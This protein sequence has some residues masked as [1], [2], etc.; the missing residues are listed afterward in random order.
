M[1]RVMDYRLL[2]HSRLRVSRLSLG[3]WNTFEFMATEDALAVMSSAVHSGIN[4]LDDAR[5]D[6]TSGKAPLKTGYSEFVFGNLL[7]GGGFKRDALVISNRLWFEF[8]PKESFEAEVDGSLSRIGID[9]FD[10]VFCYTPPKELAPAELVGQLADLIATGKIR[11]WAPANWPIELIAECCAIAKRTG[12][13]LPP[14]AMVPYSLA[15]RSSVE[16]D[17]MEAL[18]RDY[19]IGLVASFA[20][21]GG[22]LTGKYNSATAGK[23]TRYDANKLDEARQSGLLDKSARF[24][25]LTRERGFSPAQLA[26]AYCLRHPQ[27]A[28]V[29]FGAT[30][31]AQVEENVA[32]LEIAERLDDDELLAKLDAIFPKV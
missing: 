24:V 1:E 27:V 26:Y 8:F 21:H 19:D 4:F 9:Y 2:G 30:S 25:A 11:Y 29:L 23:S 6:D 32:A 18:C 17:A 13:P 12:A 7:R 20:L 14:A 16:N 15:I 3:S 5:Y 28:T 22:I 10:L 31:T